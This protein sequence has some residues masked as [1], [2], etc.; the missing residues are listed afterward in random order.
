MIVEQ[1][2]AAREGFVLSADSA[3]TVTGLL[4]VTAGQCG[5]T[6]K[7]RVSRNMTVNTHKK[8]INI[9]IPTEKDSYHIVS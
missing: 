6:R 4:Q 1:R 9:I 7:L 2:C 5:Y 3:E 8:G